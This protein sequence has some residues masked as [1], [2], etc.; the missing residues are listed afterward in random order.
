MVMDSWVLV[1]VERR[2]SDTVKKLRQ[3]VI[4]NVLIILRTVVYPGC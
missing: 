3:I 1:T 4:T 2:R